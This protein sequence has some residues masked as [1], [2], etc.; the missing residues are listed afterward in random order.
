MQRPLESPPPHPLCMCLFTA[1]I[2]E[3]IPFIVV[4]WA[5]DILSDL[6]QP[7]SG[8]ISQLSLCMCVSTCSPIKSTCDKWK[9]CFFTSGTCRCRWELTRKLFSGSLVMRKALAN[10]EAI[11]ALSF[12]TSPSWP[13]EKHTSSEW[14]F[15]HM[16]QQM[17]LALL[18]IFYLLNKK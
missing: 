16:I 11:F 7:F 13:A 5:S 2:S 18:L 6:G 9:S 12:M 10:V 17:W 4:T 3:V 15:Q 14:T 1:S 8:G